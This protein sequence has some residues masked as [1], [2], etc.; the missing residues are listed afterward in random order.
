MMVNLK[1]LFRANKMEI[2]QNVRRVELTKPNS[3]WPQLFTD[4]AN[5]IKAILKDNCVDIHHIGSTAIPNIY[6][7]P[8]I[9]ML[10]VVK[11]IRSIDALNP[12][13]EALG[14][15]CMG[16]YGIPGRRYYQKSKTKRT[17]H[18]HLFEQGSAEIQRHLAFRD[19]MRGHQDYAKAYSVLKCC[20]AD[21]FLYDIDNYVNA[22]N[23]FIQI[24]DY[25]TGMAQ[26]K[27]LKAEDNIVIES[28]DPAWPK[29]A[30]AEINA[31]K[32]IA[33][34]LPFVAIEHMGSTAVA[35][36]SS[37][38]IIDILIAVESIDDA[39]HWIDPIKTLGYLFWEDNPDKTHLRFV[40]GLPPFGE[41][42]THHVHIVEA[43]NDTFKQRILFRDLLRQDKQ[44]RQQYESL[45]LKLSQQYPTDR[46][47]YTEQKAAFI[48][49]VLQAHGYF[50]PI[51]R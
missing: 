17:H 48:E 15:S 8:I 51:A 44:S 9:D 49:S 25:K 43:K 28:Y 27:Q 34:P 40:K 20:L 16:E 39:K 46:E 22:K 7:K 21:V 30:L 11:D 47:R 31:I 23:S 24:I 41:K 3:A 1:V 18:V 32:K 4:A 5:E 13:F 26:D 36:L 6:A 12:K 10:P 50:N 42:R 38:P 29:L 37:K 14:Y 35:E 2:N 19:F 45:K 33:N